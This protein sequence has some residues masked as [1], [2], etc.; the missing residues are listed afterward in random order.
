MF[1]N[2]NDFENGCKNCAACEL[3]RTRRN[4]VVGRGSK[5]AK[6]L[7]VGEAPG[8]QEDL[9]GLP[10]VGAAGQLLDLLLEA[11]KIDKEDFY[12]ANIIKCRPPA[13]RDPSEEEANA[14]MPFLRNQFLL[15]KPKAV[16]CLGRIA[17]K[18]MIDPDFKITSE[19]GKWID[20][21]GT[22]FM[23]TFHPAAVLHDREGGEIKKKNMF[24][25]M[26][27]VRD[28]LYEES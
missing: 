4:V 7:F 3:S 1:N 13:N 22:K 23:A 14:C 20:R 28:F 5:N 25:D 26:L 6:I 15:L 24:D 12:I 17:A 16:I 8:E 19:R 27:K 11:C 21:K 2:W 10:F 9:R 18:N